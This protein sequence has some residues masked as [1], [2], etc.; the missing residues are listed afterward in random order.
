[1]GKKDRV[2]LPKPCD[3]CGINADTQFRI[4]C[5]DEDTWRIV[6]KACQE[7]AKACNGYMYGGTWK[8]KKRN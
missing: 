5:G 8:R 1:M 2:R 7:R 6:C 4:R 3:N